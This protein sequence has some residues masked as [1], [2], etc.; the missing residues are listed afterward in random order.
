MGLDKGHRLTDAPKDVTIRARIDR[1]TV[2]KLDVLTAETGLTR[3]DV[4][5]K[6][7]DIQYE[8]HTKKS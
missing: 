3:S 4:I 7:I 2:E 8:A 6:G 1:E 5:R